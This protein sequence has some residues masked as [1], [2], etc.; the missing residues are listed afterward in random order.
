[1]REWIILIIAGLSIIIFLYYIFVVL[2]Y[3]III[4]NAFFKLKSNMKIVSANIDLESENLGKISILVPAFNESDTILDT[5]QSLMK[6]DYND[7][8]VIVVNDGSEDDTLNKLIDYFKLKPLPIYY[9]HQLDCKRIRGVYTE[10]KHPG[11]LIVV[12]KENGGKADSLNAAINF[13]RNRYICCIDADCILESQALKKVIRIFARRQ[14]T[15]A[16][17]GMVKVINGCE[18]TNGKVN[19]VNLPKT[20]IER[21]QIIEYLRAFLSSRFTWNTNNG[22]LI[23][24]GAFGMFDKEAV[25]AVG[26]YRAGLGEDMELVVRLQEYHNHN[27]IPYSISMA[28][29]AVCWTQ[30]PT[31]YKDLKIQR[32]RWHKGLIDSLMTHK[33]MLLNPDYGFV[34]MLAFPLQFFVEMLG[35]L[36]EVAGYILVFILLFFFKMTSAALW[37][38]LMAYLY[39][40]FQTIFAVIFERMTYNIYGSKKNTLRL[41]ATCFLEPIFYRPVTVW[42]RVKA[43]ITFREKHNWGRIKRKQF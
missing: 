38:F 18:V 15:I 14:E 9:H 43:F 27:K 25:L 8:E 40:V 30:V 22:N 7:Y 4:V 10:L 31:R 1:M 20:F 13:S 42:W 5:V 33:K 6:I 34:G 16:V 12:D 36:I 26:G 2:S 28:S 37:I 21:V 23:I 19:R 24:S 39:G 41:L 3:W 11:R 17:G 29:D 35:P 32:V